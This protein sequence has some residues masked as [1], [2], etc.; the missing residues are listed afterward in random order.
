[1]EADNRLFRPGTLLDTRDHERMVRRDWRDANDLPD[2]GA[3]I[4][5]L[6]A[7]AFDL[8]ARRGTG[9]DSRVRARYEEA[10]ALLHR[11]G[12]RARALLRA[13]VALQVLEEQWDDVFYVHQLVQEY[14]AARSVAATPRPE[15]VQTRWRASEL[16]PSLEALLR[17]LPDSDPLPQAP[18]TG[19]EETY[20]LAAAMVREPD[21]FVAALA[22]R[23]LPLAGRCAAQP[24]VRVS[25]ELRRRLQRALIER[26]RDPAAD[27]RARIAAARALGELGDPRFERRRG[28]DSEYLHPPAL[29][30]AGGVYRIGSDEGLFKDEA[31]VHEV[32]LAPFAIGQFPITNAEWRLFLEAGGYEDKRWWDT[33]AARAWRRGEGTAEGPK[34]MWRDWRQQFHPNPALIR[35]AH[36]TG[37]ITSKQAEE[38]KDWARRSDA[39]FEALLD[40]WFP[41][42]RQTRPGSWEDPGFNHP[43]QPVVG[44]CW[45]EARAYCAWLSAQTGQ[46]YRLP[47]EAEWEAAVR[48]HE[49]R[50]Y[51]WVGDFDPARCNVFETHVRG[52]TPPGVFPGGDTPDGLVDMVGNV[53]EWTSTCYRPY[54]YRGDDGC[55]DPEFVDVRRVVRG[56]DW[57]GDRDFA[58]CAYRS[59]GHPGSRDGN[60]GFRVVRG[61]PLR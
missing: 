47:T 56:G 59:S 9:E 38:W 61:S 14:F 32:T 24:D 13:G 16:S 21:R 2:R 11:D 29:T 40:Q 52:T 50:R 45:Y 53:W 3:L 36:R 48:A 58:R 20:V 54:P 33:D 4:P 46:P 28:P 12:E 42:G 26:S 41:P 8:Q 30:I 1:V 27:L 23:N 43:A 10:L 35:E 6:G 49:G 60:L 7:L 37:K 39:E 5:A 19:W 15:L 57:T 22:E 51:A 34:Q 31:P 55:E 25:A 44:I 18:A 17:S